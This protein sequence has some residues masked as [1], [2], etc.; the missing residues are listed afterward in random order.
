MKGRKFVDSP[1]ALLFL[2]LMTVPLGGQAE[3]G[4][5]TEKGL[6][7]VSMTVDGKDLAVG[8]NALVLAIR[9]RQNRDLTGAEV[10]VTP[11]MPEHGHGVWEKPLVTERANGNY[12]VEN[13]VLIMSGRWDLKVSV[14]KGTE[15][16]QA[17]FSFTVGAGGKPA[18]KAFEKP[19][20]EYARGVAHYKV[21]NVTLLNQDGRKVRLASLL[22]SGKPVI[23]QFVYTTCTTICPILS[24]GFSGLRD[25]LGEASPS[26]QLVSISIDP[27]HD[28]PERLKE[29]LRRYNSGEGW[30]F[31]TGTREDIT[32]VLRAF[33]AYVPDKMS[34]Q[35]V[36][37]LRG[38]SSDDWVRLTGLI[39]AS[40]LM[41]EFR[42][43]ERR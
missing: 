31:L 25:E 8:P 29:Y 28:R 10:A 21:P 32:L 12:R 4:Q 24:A 6:F 33:N 37:L 38:P 14:R 27:E 2:L 42:K 17:V 11:W 36:F 5:G 3:K 40:D 23:V 1:G 19:K 9:D 35:P 34:H 18:P 39:G 43:I 41:R 15:E 30:D 20:T 16:D 22:D 13:V 7:T 26:V